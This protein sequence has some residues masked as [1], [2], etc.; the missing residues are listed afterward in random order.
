MA[1]IIGNTG[2]HGDKPQDRG[3]GGEH[4]RPESGGAGADYR[5]FESHPAF[6][7]FIDVIDENNGVV[8]HH[9]GKGYDTDTGHDNAKR[10][11]E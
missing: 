10:L 8:H 1:K 11:L 4:H 7:K 3:N 5:F 9:T 6:S 2:H